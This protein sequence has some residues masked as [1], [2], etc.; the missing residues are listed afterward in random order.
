MFKAD[1]PE[2]LRPVGETEFVNGIAAM[3]ASETYGKTKIAAAIIGTV[4]LRVGELAGEV[5]DAHI[6]A[7]GGRF[8]GIRRA[9]AWDA[10]DVIKNHRTDPPQSLLLQED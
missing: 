9:V 2:Y 10:A 5:L 7:G 4:D 8:R 3:S 6:A 1:G